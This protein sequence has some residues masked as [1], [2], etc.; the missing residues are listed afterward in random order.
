MSNYNAYDFNEEYYIEPNV[1]E[2]DDHKNNWNNLD[3]ISNIHPN[4]YIKE[5]LQE[6]NII[7]DRN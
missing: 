2:I 4:N 1:N 5:W 6:T 3:Y 7:N